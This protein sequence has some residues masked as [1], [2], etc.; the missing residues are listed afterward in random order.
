MTLALITVNASEHAAL[1]AERDALRVQVTE[2]Q[3]A[4]TKMADRTLARRVRAF[5]QKFG[6]PVRWTPTVPP[7]AEV[8][9]RLAL[10]L[11]EFE[12]LLLSTLA[13]P[14]DHEWGDFDGIH[15]AVEA[16]TAE[17]RELIRLA[18]VGVDLPEAYD[19]LLDLGWVV[20]GTHAVIGTNA[21]PG[22]E[23]VGRAN[24]DKDPVYVALKDGFH[25]SNVEERSERPDPTQK[26]RKPPGW[27]G[28]DIVGVLRAQGWRP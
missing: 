12:E 22:F 17:L 7:D 23:E 5:H 19:A 13:D 25:G 6:H 21:D 8:R 20:E 11:E 15:E 28:P 27:R 1:I 2:L 24:M 9:F 18:P 4:M 14:E 3:A 16:A 10:I 26:P